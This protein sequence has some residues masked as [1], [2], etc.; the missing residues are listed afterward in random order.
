M[1]QRK[2]AFRAWDKVKKEMNYKVLAGNTDIDDPNYTCN[3]ILQKEPIR[4]VNADHFCIVLMQFTGK[5]DC[6]GKDVYE[7]DVISSDQWNPKN[8]KVIFEEGEFCFVS[9]RG[10]E[11]PYTNS[12]SYV[13]DFEVIGNIYE[14]PELLS[15]DAQV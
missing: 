2:I 3:A 6:Q 13:K 14:N 7:G 9:L 10:V 5:K 1:E 8:Y 12:I 11:S 15:E 4:W